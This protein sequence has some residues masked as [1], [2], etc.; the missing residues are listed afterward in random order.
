MPFFNR[1][2]Y[3]PLGSVDGKIDQVLLIVPGNSPVEMARFL[4]SR[5]WMWEAFNDRVKFVVYGHTTDSGLRQLNVTERGKQKDKVTKE[6]LNYI[7]ENAANP[8][9][10]TMFHLQPMEECPV[11]GFPNL[12]EYAQDPF[13]VL[14]GEEDE[15]I[16]LESKANPSARNR[17]IAEDL[18]GSSSKAIHRPTDLLLEGGN[19][20]FGNDYG[21]MGRDCFEKNLKR[22]FAEGEGNHVQALKAQIREELGIDYLIVPEIPTFTPPEG[23]S[24]IRWGDGFQALYHIDL[25]MTLGGK[26]HA[27]NEQLIFI[28]DLHPYWDP[29]RPDDPKG[30][31]DWPD[32]FQLLKAKLDETAQFFRDYSEQS[33]EGPNFHVIRV[34]LIW[35][36]R[37]AEG[38]ILRSY[39]NC[40]V[41][42]HRGT[43]TYY[44]PSYDD[45]QRLFNNK[46]SHE[47]R[48]Y[49]Y[50]SFQYKHHVQWV[51]EN[52]NSRA[53]KAASL[54]CIVKV[55]NRI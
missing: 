28:G 31:I 37:S 46:R 15:A 13:V 30:K 40:M 25:Y 2:P 18:S 6:M 33:N 48:V 3:H 9:S 16:F 52:F 19:L 22:L 8:E 39:N 42:T 7:S 50:F 54:H 36:N 45:H 4:E 26:H 14:K 27:R 12:Q 20:L 49:D 44:L 43:T 5:K 41:E 53:H 47:R 51:N 34:P 17:F 21:I 29:E 10:I 35:E 32:H 55:L 11:D 38:A 23:G 24:R 1:P